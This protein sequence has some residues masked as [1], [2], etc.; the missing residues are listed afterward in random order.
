MILDFNKRFLILLYS[1]IKPGVGGLVYIWV[2]HV[3]KGPPWLWDPTRLLESNLVCSKDLGGT[4]VMDD[5]CV[6]VAF[7][8]F[9]LTWVGFDPCTSTQL[10]NIPTLLWLTVD[11]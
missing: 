11:P 8:Q 6:K 10:T 2:M 7:H 1:C 4:K 9:I 3:Y 5:F